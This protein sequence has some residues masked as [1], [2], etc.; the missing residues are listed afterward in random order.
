MNKI[1][2][3]LFIASL[4]LYGLMTP[5]DAQAQHAL[6]PSHFDLSEV[7]L[8]DS[9]FKRAQD[10]NYKTLLEYD[11]D[12]MLTP[13]IRQAG[14]S[15][16]HDGNS[17][18]YSWEVDHPA[19]ENW[20]WNPTLAMDGHITGHYLS[21]L[22]ISYSSCHDAA[23]KAKLKQ[24]MDYMV[25]VMADC[26]AVYSQDKRGMRGFIGGLPDNEIW[27]TLYSGDYRVYNQRGIWVPFY[28]EHK[29]MAGLRD[30]YVYG[31]NEK[32]KAAF[33]AMCDWVIDVVKNFRE[34][35]M[36]MQILQWEPGGINEVLADAYYLFGESKYY[37]AAE[38]YSHQI[39]IENMVRDDRHDFLDQ[40]NSNEAAAKF[41]GFA[42][43]NDVKSDER[44]EKASRLFWSDVVSA[45]TTAIGGAGVNNYFQPANKLSRY[46][47]EA[48]GPDACTTYN[49]LKL[50]RLLFNYS[51]QSRYADYYENALLNHILSNQDPETGGYVYYTATRPNTYRMYSQVNEAMWC[52]V[53]TGMESQSKYGEFIYSYVKDTLFVNLFIG[54]ELQNEKI[55]LRQESQFPYGQKSTITI[56]KPGNYVLAVRRP[57]WTN[58]QFSV[59]VNGKA[60]KKFEAVRAGE[61][62][63]YVSCGKG[64]KAGDVIEVSYPMSLSFAECP[65]V[66]TYIALKY[67][68]TVLAAVTERSSKAKPFFNEY[69]GE[70]KRDHSNTARQKPQSLALA[71]MI[72]SDRAQVPGRIRVEDQSKLVFNVDASATGSTYGLVEMR[73][74]FD[75]QHG[76][77]TIYWNQ[78]P[79]TA[80]LRN[81]LYLRELR[82]NTLEAITLDLVDVGNDAS[83]TAHKIKLSETGSCGTL[84][85]QTFRDCQPDQWFELGFD[86][87]KGA[88]DLAKAD[89]VTLLLHLSLADRGRGGVISVDGKP[90]HKLVIPT[91]AKGSGKDKFFDMPVVISAQH[92]RGKM[93]SRIR[94]QAES[95]AFFPRLYNARLLKYDADVV[96]GY[97]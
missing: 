16:T 61:R 17:R 75:T 85:E 66:P 80:W 73:P 89:S 28:C 24:R 20:A 9:P 84:N 8:L 18:Y 64:W 2:N 11:V 48:D 65:K 86:L 81:P 4:T 47:S 10:L 31:G 22:A 58:A 82:N 19:F 57:D 53:G 34:D 50:S 43:I 44:Y 45:R 3:L 6:Y 68:P 12:R 35:I 21:A 94:F 56:T 13:L 7:T 14:L 37:K 90:V 83:E 5:R 40:K 29:I 79:E 97:R 74:F 15:Q 69:A 51:R 38:K 62:S 92:F 49:M 39:M 30:A 27:K 26:Q 36:E 67:G 88:S 95:T 55:G 91:T 77:Y 72:I 41:V 78:Q 59:L 76:R 52:C 93:V 25:D 32:A 63:F 87:S 71:P 33:R 23:M 70:G 1:L 54:S 46:I 42:R 96:K 60:P